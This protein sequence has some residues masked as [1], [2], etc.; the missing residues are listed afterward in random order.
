MVDL[1]ISYSIEGMD[2]NHVRDSN[3]TAYLPI[4]YRFKRKDGSVVTNRCPE[5]SPVQKEL[6]LSIAR[7][8]DIDMYGA[9]KRLKRST[10]SIQGAM[11]RLSQESLIKVSRTEKS[12]RGVTDKVIY[13]LTPRG[14]FVTI[15]LL[16]ENLPTPRSDLDLGVGSYFDAHCAFQE[17]VFQIYQKH[18]DFNSEILDVLPNFADD[19]KNLSTNYVFGISDDLIIGSTM[20]IVYTMKRL[21]DLKPDDLGVSA[22]NLPNDGD[23]CSFG[24]AL[25]G[26]IVQTTLDHDDDLVAILK[27]YPSVWVKV[28]ADLEQKMSVMQNDMAR[29]TEILER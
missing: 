14:Y 20:G 3:G 7:E 28:R 26:G 18:T 12:R 17:E 23:F 2:I 10:S 6:L 29:I 15:L 9:G 25:I 24:S 27:K 4:S 1:P 19:L 11:K 16:G 13:T 21:D 5:L 22:T 8:G